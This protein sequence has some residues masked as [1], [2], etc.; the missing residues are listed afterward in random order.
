MDFD[1]L[2]FSLCLKIVVGTR[3]IRACPPSI[4]QWMVELLLMEVK[5]GVHIGEILATAIEY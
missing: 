4:S 2:L 3:I 5:V 1:E